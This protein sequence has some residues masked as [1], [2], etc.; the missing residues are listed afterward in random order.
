MADLENDKITDKELP[1]NKKKSKKLTP[2]MKNII[3]P[4]EKLKPQTRLGIKKLV[5]KINVTEG[6]TTP[7]NLTQQELAINNSDNNDKKT[8]IVNEKSPIQSEKLKE[9]NEM[10]FYLKELKEKT[11]EELAKLAEELNVKNAANLQRHDMIFAILKCVAEQGGVMIGEGVLEILQDG[12]GFLRSPMANYVPGSDDIY[13]SPNQ[14]RRYGLRTGDTK[15]SQT[16]KRRTLFC[17]D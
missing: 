13:V 5:K 9:K 8:D 6:T 16:K 7:E 17:L 10:V 3:P 1:E 11:P 15:F 14:I 4:K 12:Y 2:D